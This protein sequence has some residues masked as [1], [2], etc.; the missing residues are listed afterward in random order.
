MQFMAG[1]VRLGK[2]SKDELT[3]VLVMLYPNK[4]EEE[5]D[6]IMKQLCEG[7]EFPEDKPDKEKAESMEDR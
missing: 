5:R 6:E 4:K 3:N 7:Y 1:L 2:F